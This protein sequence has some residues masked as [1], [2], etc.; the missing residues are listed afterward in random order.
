MGRVEICGLGTGGTSKSNVTVRRNTFLNLGQQY[1]GFP[2][3]E[4]DCDSGSNNLI[5]RNIAQDPDGGFANGGSLSVGTFLENLWR[6]GDAANALA[7]DAAANC[8]SA[9]CNPPGQPPIGYRKPS[10]VNW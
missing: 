3:F 9:T 8:T 6:D 2:S 5:E 1:N 10:G 4:W 7:F